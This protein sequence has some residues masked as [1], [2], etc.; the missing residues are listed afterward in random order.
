MEG[1]EQAGLARSSCGA[2]TPLPPG[3]ELAPDCAAPVPEPQLSAEED[4]ALV[5]APPRAE[6]VD[7]S[8]DRLCL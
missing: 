7:A 6:R 3:M 1:G 4:S 8:S 2:A 5:R